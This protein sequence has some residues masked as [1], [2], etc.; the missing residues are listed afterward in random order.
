MHNLLPDYIHFL[1]AKKI[2]MK[3]NSFQ[4]RDIVIQ[5]RIRQDVDGLGL[6]ILNYISLLHSTASD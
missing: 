1:P 2:I 4:K 6:A 3:E 5:K